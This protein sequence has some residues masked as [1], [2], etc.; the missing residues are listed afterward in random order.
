MYICIVCIVCIYMLC[1]LCIRIRIRMHVFMKY[2][3]TYTYVH[4]CSCGPTHRRFLAMAARL[5]DRSTLLSSLRRASASARRQ[6]RSLSVSLS[7]SLSACPCLLNSPNHIVFSSSQCLQ[8]EV[9]CTAEIQKLHERSAR[10]NNTFGLFV[11]CRFLICNGCVLCPHSL[12]E[13]SFH[14][15][16]WLFMSMF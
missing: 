5:L 11:V 3:Y 14:V 13:S 8:S 7:L 9:P 15:R 6:V 4:I 2:T 1:L 16:E 12:P 10:I